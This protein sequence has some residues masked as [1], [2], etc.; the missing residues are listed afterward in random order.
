VLKTSDRSLP[1]IF[2]CIIQALSHKKGLRVSNPT[3]IVLPV[4]LNIRGFQARR[5][6]LRRMSLGHL[7][8]RTADTRGMS[9]VSL[10]PDP[11]K[12]YSPAC[13]DRALNISTRAGGM[14]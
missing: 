9:A 4:S 6:P 11:G 3:F 2:T 13:P 12:I 1:G 5:N 7:P 8:A 14:L 10:A